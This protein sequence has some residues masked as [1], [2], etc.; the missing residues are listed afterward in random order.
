V[1]YQFTRRH[2]LRWIADYDSVLPNARWTSLTKDKRLNL[3][4]LYTYMLNPGTALH[5]GFTDQRENY[6]LDPLQSPALQ[7]VPGLDLST[8]RQ[9]FVKLSYLFRF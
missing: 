8:G 6:R 9:I 5:I 7:R 2:S 3:D 4:A 1:N